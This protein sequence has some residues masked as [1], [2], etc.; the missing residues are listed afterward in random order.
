MDAR[1]RERVVALRGMILRVQPSARQHEFFITVPDENLQDLLDWRAM[2]L[3]CRT[4]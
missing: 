2:L 1:I 3:G 4:K